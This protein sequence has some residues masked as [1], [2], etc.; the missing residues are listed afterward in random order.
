MKNIRVYMNVAFCLTA[1]N[2]FEKDVRPFVQD[3]LSTPQKIAPYK[4]IAR[5][6]REWPASKKASFIHFVVNNP[7]YTFRTWMS[8]N[9]TR[10]SA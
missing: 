2:S 10:N 5:Q 9:L 1:I 4:Y 3:Y 6:C 7:R 8:Q